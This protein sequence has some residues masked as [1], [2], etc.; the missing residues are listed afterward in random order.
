MSTLVGGDF[1]KKVQMQVYKGTVHASKNNL[2]WYSAVELKSASAVAGAEK[3]TVSVELSDKYENTGL[4]AQIT[5]GEKGDPTTSVLNSIA[6][7]PVRVNGE[8]SKTSFTCE[9]TNGIVLGKQYEL[10]VAVENA[11]GSSNAKPLITTMTSYNPGLVDIKKFDSLDAS[12]AVFDFTVAK[13]DYSKYNSLTLLLDFKQ[14][15]AAVGSTQQ[16][17][18]DI[19]GTTN[20]LA[21]TANRTFDMN[22]LIMTSGNKQAITLGSKFDVVAK[23]QATIDI[24]GLV[25]TKTY[26]GEAATATYTMDQNMGNPVITLHEIDWTSGSQTVKAVVDGS[27]N[28]MTFKFDLSG[29]ESTTTSYDVCNN[30]M[31]ATKIY[32][33]S[34]LNQVGKVVKVS[35]S[36]PEVNGGASISKSGP[37]ALAYPLKAIKRSLAPSVVIDFTINKDDI[38]KTDTKFSFTSIPDLSFSDLFGRVKGEGI[39]ASAAVVRD[40]SGNATIK[41]TEVF[42][43]GA[44][45]TASGHSRFDL[46][47]NSAG[48]HGR[49]TELNKNDRYLLSVGVESQIAYKGVPQVELSVRPVHASSNELK[50]VRVSGD[51]KANDVSELM[52]I[53]R[54]VCGNIIHKKLAVTATS[55]DSCG[56]NL[57]GSGG[58]DI[59]TTFAHDFVFDK[60]IEIGTNMFL[61]GI[62]DTPSSFDAIRTEVAPAAA[63]TAFKAA[64]VEHNDAVSS[65][66]L[67]LSNNPLKDTVYAGHVSKIASYDISLANLTRDISAAILIRDG[68]ANGS[69][70][71]AAKKAA[72][73]TVAQKKQTNAET[74]YNNIRQA[75]SL[76]EASMNPLTVGV[77]AAQRLQYNASG[78][79]TFNTY[80]Y[81]ATNDASLVPITVTG[82]SA[83]F[84][85]VQLDSQSQ[86]YGHAYTTAIQ[87]L[88]N[89]FNAVEAANHANDEIDTIISNKEAQKSTETTGRGTS[90]QNRDDRAG[91]LVSAAASAGTRI[92]NAKT[93]LAA[94]RLAFFPE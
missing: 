54:D 48:F 72:E 45:Y 25:G 18:I 30:K 6:L 44:R 55:V 16:H 52:C 38:T 14:N 36:R 85:E 49:Y 76:F 79:I 93:A 51:M 80:V 43:P 67:D 42:A 17:T 75:V 13:F 58:N 20:I 7:T 78:S 82:T 83:S 73:Y 59:A 3:I 37:T 50:V 65:N 77:T 68:S 92:T 5:V 11:Y 9:L 24:S 57:S 31:T 22:R 39:D 4:T 26:V 88:T 89:A 40:N 64:A 47:A 33:Y 32:S 53:A 46:G 1:T 94:A 28:N 10:Q 74:N 34:E 69:E 84:L 66:A 19:C 60:E 35:A 12:G 56:N 15:N 27:F 86:V 21:P 61:L 70:W 29:A 8:D 63:A 41:L 23:L 91:D 71:Y 62:V 2:A 81:T 87:N 90:V